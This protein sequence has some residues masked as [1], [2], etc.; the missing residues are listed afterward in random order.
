MA[1]S[2][3]HRFVRKT[4]SASIGFTGMFR[5]LAANAERMRVR[6]RGVREGGETGTRD[7]GRGISGGGRGDMK[8]AMSDENKEP[9]H[10]GHKHGDS[11]LV[12]RPSSLIPDSLFTCPMHPEVISDKPG[13]CPIC[14][15]TL[16]P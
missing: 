7:E 10:E 14:G 2:I 3:R 13:F 12:P 9:C 15:M 1:L 4:S 5:S 16:E 11:P 6:I 8:S